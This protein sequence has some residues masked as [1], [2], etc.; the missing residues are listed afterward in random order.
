MLEFASTMGSRNSS[1]KSTLALSTVKMRPTIFLAQGI[2]HANSPM[3]VRRVDGRNKGSTQWDMAPHGCLAVKNF[4]RPFSGVAS[5]CHFSSWNWI[6]ARRNAGRET[7]N[8]YAL[9]TFRAPWYADKR[10]KGGLGSANVKCPIALCGHNKWD[11]AFPRA[12]YKPLHMAGESYSWGQYYG[13]IVASWMER[14]ICPLGV[15]SG[16]TLSTSPFIIPH[17]S[18]SL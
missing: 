17:W 1:L 15:L 4:P 11:G 16:C 18:I 7:P 5:A 6:G 8:I 2:I 13:R 14:C 3:K 10:G 9:A 12:E